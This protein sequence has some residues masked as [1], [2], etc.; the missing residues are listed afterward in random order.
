MKRRI[1]LRNVGLAT[2][3]G[4]AVGV[5]GLSAIQP[6]RTILPFAVADNDALP[7]R[8]AVAKRVVV[9]VAVWPASPQ[10]MNY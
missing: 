1:F 8:P 4:T 3:A 6:R 9:V 7:E 10:P 5:A 2:L